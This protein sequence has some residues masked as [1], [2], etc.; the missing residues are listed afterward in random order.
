LD[1]RPRHSGHRT[2]ADPSGAGLP[3]ST[4][5]INSPVA[6]QQGISVTL[7]ADGNTAIVGGR[8]DNNYAGAALVF[9]RTSGVWT[10]QGDKLVGTGAVGTNIQQGISVSLSEDGNT[11]IVGRMATAR[12]LGRP[13]YMSR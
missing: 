5:A 12:A 4:G 1:R 3:I 9:T 8:N 11:A 6:A 7:S 13:G 10:Q 2:A